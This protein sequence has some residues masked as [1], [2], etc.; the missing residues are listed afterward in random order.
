[1]NF[2]I[3]VLSLVFYFYKSRKPQKKKFSKKTERSY[4]KYLLIVL[5]IISLLIF[6][7]NSDQLLF[8]RSRSIENTI[9]IALSMTTFFFA[10]AI[11]Y[12][13]PSNNRKYIISLDYPSR[14]ESKKGEILL[15]RVL[16]DDKTKHKF[17]LSMSDL[18]RHMFV[19]G[20]TGSGKS[21]LF[22]YFLINLTKKYNIPFLLA[23]FKGEYHYLQENIKDLV[24]LKPGINFSLNIFD[25]GNSNSHIH[26]ERVFQI[27][28][29][30]GLFQNVE[31]SPQMERVFIAILNEVCRDPEKRSWE[32]F[33]EICKKKLISDVDVVNSLDKSVDAILNRIRRYSL[34]TLSHIFVSQKTEFPVKKIFDHRV[35]LDLSSIIRLGGEK[36]DALFF[37]NMI[38]KYLWDQNIERGSKDY[39]GIRH[40]TIIEDGQYFAPS[41]LSEATKLTSYIEDIALLL[42]GTGECLITLAT[43]PDVSKEILANAGVRICFSLDV[44][45]DIMQEMLNLKG[46]Q[47]YYL[48]ELGTGK[49]I[50]KVHSIEKPFVLTVPQ[51]ERKWLSVEEIEN[52]NKEILG[53]D[54][55]TD[56]NANPF[57]ITFCFFCGEEMRGDSTY[58]EKC[59]T[60]LKEDEKK[61]KQV[62]KMAE[63]TQKK[64]KN[65]I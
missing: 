26:A 45:R 64:K 43:R 52:R 37:L 15:G 62:I 3:F 13:S 58:C 12:L 65:R 63:N 47:K 60:I 16:C 38:L 55:G 6:S 8:D 30:G 46:G 2:T 19:A 57:E 44:Q 18:E 42:R 40:I 4:V 21:N 39:K 20:K 61:F 24:V 36:D 27:F 25:P 29:S 23:E 9:L 32:K 11:I 49:C 1:M 31:Y 14:K 56:Y 48:S 53:D 10:G 22:Q 34:G 41:H 33:I 35:L 51:M 28:K 54:Y 17:F 7:F 59:Q 50:V 5:L